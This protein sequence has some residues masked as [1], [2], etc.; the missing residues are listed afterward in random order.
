MPEYCFLLHFLP[1]RAILSGVNIMGILQKN[2]KVLLI[3]LSF[4]PI[5]NY[6]DFKKPTLF[7][8]AP[9]NTIPGNLFKHFEH[10]RL[11]L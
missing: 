1:Y 10:D 8:N 5:I 9:V 6:H 7:L 11:P 2:M 4:R 3:V